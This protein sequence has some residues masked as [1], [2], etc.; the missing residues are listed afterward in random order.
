MWKMWSYD[1]VYF[2]MFSLL[3][4]SKKHSQFHYYV[5]LRIW[6]PGQ[7]IHNH[8]L[9]GETMQAEKTFQSKQDTTL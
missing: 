4:F 8:G 6:P 5:T 7:S 1:P 3:G 2:E 9:L